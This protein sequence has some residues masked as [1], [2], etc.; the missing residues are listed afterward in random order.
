MS[1]PA[2]MVK[3][4]SYLKGLVETRA[5]AD[6]YIQRLDAVIGEAQERLAKAKAER[7]ACDT[8]IGAYNPSLDP[9]SIEPIRAWRGRYGKRG[10]RVQALR[11][12]VRAAYPQAVS[13][14]EAAWHLALKFEMDFANAKAREQW[15]KMAVRNPLRLMAEQGEI[16]RLELEG[17]EGLMTSSWRWV[18]K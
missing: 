9:N 7:D 13:T 3:V 5:R 10:E 17:L 2:T 12:F 14:A 18:P 11:D 15:K 16:E 8:L 4:P 6:A 1:L